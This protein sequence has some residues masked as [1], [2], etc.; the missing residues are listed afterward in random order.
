VPLSPLSRTHGHDRTKYL[1]RKR[2]KERKRRRKQIKREAG[3]N[4]S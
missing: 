2:K 3:E 1:K 4:K